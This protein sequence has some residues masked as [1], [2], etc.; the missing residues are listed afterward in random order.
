MC[1][2]TETSQM[3]SKPS[4][5]KRVP[6]TLDFIEVI[7]AALKAHAEKRLQAQI[8]TPRQ[9]KLAKEAGGVTCLYRVP[10]KPNCGCAIGVAMTP[11]TLE[12][13]R[14]AEKE[15]GTTMSISAIRSRGVVRYSDA[16]AQLFSELQTS[17]DYWA[18]GTFNEQDFLTRL[19]MLRTECLA[20]RKARAA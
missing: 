12:R 14:L 15:E 16:E 9:R 19:D 7:D 6:Q 13:V 18:D 17:H 11:E 10:R 3:P 4:P 2:E 5:S 1:I 8:I 20:Q